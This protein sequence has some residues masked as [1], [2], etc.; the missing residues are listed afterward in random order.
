MLQHVALQPHVLQCACYNNVRRGL[1]RYVIRLDPFAPRAGDFP[2]SGHAPGPHR[3]VA[4]PRDTM[5]MKRASSPVVSRFARRIRHRRHPSP[6]CPKLSR[7]QSRL[8]PVKGFCSTCPCHRRME[9]GAKRSRNTRPM[10]SHVGRLA[11]KLP[12]T[13]PPRLGLVP[14]PSR[15]EPLAPEPP[16]TAAMS[17]V[18]PPAS[19]RERERK[20]ERETSGW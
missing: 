12:L 20:R 7:A 3:C 13:A 17:S 11:R 1:V 10:S 5:S 9:M 14:E 8:T 6:P 16:R 19:D 4:S 15:L 2:P 18:P